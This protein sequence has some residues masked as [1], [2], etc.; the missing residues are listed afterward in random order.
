MTDLSM[1]AISGYPPSWYF[2]ANSS[3]Q[4]QNTRTHATRARG[5][6]P[7]AGETGASCRGAGPA[8]VL[9]H[10]DGVPAALD[11]P[12]G[13]GVHQVRSLVEQGGPEG[14]C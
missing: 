14:Q 13:H 11:V 7:A 4:Q 10:L 5:R 1:S 9:C 6:W 2:C 12:K 3:C 8:R